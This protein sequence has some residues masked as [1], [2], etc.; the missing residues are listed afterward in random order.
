MKMTTKI[1]T[2]SELVRLHSFE[3]RFEYLKLTGVVGEV[4]FGG[5]RQ[6]NQILYQTK[7]WKNTR[8]KVILRDGGNDL[9]HPDYPIRGLIYIH[10]INPVTISDILDRRSCVFDLNNLVS[11]SFDTHNAIHYGSDEIIKK[12][13]V[14]IRTPGDTALW[15]MKGGGHDC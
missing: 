8:R 14:V 5:H 13:E 15:K 11:C 9:S 12:R 1:K 10:H 7:E 3:D 4:T 6:L 2:Y